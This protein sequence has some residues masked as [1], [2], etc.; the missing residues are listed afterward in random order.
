MCYLF[1]ALTNESTRGDMYYDFM[2][3]CKNELAKAIFTGRPY[4]SLYTILTI[5]SH[6][7]QTLI[8]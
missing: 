5:K 6:R 4:L 1:P 3:Y 7:E 8:V 2:R